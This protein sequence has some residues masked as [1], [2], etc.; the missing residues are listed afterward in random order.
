MLTLFRPGRAN[1]AGK[2]MCAVRKDF[3]RETE[4]AGIRGQIA[5]SL[6]LRVL[7][8]VVLAFVAVAVPAYVAFTT[9]VNATV[10]QLGTLFAEKQILYDRYRGLDALMREVTLAETLAGTQAIRDWA[11]NEDDPDLRRRGIAELEHYRQSFSDQSYFFVIGASGNYYFN[12]AANGYAGDQF[13]YTLSPD[14]PRDGWY[15][16]TAALGDG[17]HLNVDNDDTLRVTK[18]WMNCVIRE[19]RQVLGILGTG[20]DLSSFIREV[21]NI[22]QVGVTAMFVDRSGAVQ[23]HRDQNLVDYHSLTKEMAD[24]KT[25]FDMVDTAADRAALSSLMDEVASGEVP[26]KSRF[27]QMGGKDVLVGVG[28]LDRLG[29]FNVTVMDVNTIIDHQLFLPIGVL[30]LVVV[31]LVVTLLVMVFRRL[32]LDRIARLESAVHAAR[33]GDFAAAAGLDDPRP[34]EI[35]RLSS[36]FA[37]MARTVGDNTEQLEARV[38]ERTEDLQRLAFRDALTGISNRRGFMAIYEG[39]SSQRDHGLLLVDIDHFKQINDTHGHAAGDAVV[40]EIAGRISGLVGPGGSSARWGG[41]EFIVLLDESGPNLLRSNAYTIMQAICEA[42]ITL[43]DGVSLT[44]TVSLGATLVQ[45]SQSIEM[46]TDMADAAL[47]AAKREGRNRVVVF[48]P[49]SLEGARILANRP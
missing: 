31:V 5:A 40:I 24:K 45:K 36:A 12:D 25:V 37:E 3:W 29:W 18:V 48:D 35:G 39:V 1:T 47:Y 44:V 33:A 28:Y 46:A 4:I 11:R 7:V 15:Y 27:M 30:L 49:D 17:C 23:A 19:G 41:D 6:K 13:R 8:V 32:V 2:A 38:R 42:P 16:N 43:P 9:L 14:N 10:I 26:V 22:P 21:V 20:L 34:D